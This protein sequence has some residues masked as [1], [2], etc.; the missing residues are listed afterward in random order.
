MHVHAH[1]PQV[2]KVKSSHKTLYFLPPKCPLVPGKKR[3][4]NL[5]GLLKLRV[6][7]ADV[8]SYIVCGL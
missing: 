1:M 3:M 8:I 4:Y 7:V 2:A 6:Q 5:E